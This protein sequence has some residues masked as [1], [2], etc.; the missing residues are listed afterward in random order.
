MS[1]EKRDRRKKT[2]QNQD[3]QDYRITRIKKFAALDV[4]RFKRIPS[5]CELVIIVCE[6]VI[7]FS[8][9]SVID[10]IYVDKQKSFL[11]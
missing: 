2:G 10:K 4:I 6:R 1:R 9:F 3:S 5:C 8:F 11:P 7:S